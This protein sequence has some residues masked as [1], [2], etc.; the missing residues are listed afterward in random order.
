[1]KRT[2]ADYLRGVYFADEDVKVEM[3]QRRIVRVRKIHTCCRCKK[4]LSVGALALFEKA[5]IE[6]HHWGRNYLCQPCMDS[7]LDE[8][9]R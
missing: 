4:K 2:D 1:M 5:K 6:G 9:G 7:I 8:A 3:L